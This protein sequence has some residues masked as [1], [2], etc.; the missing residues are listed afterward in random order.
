MTDDRRLRELEEKY[1]GYKVYDNTGDK[2]GKVDDIF[3]DEADREEYIGVKMG[4]FGSRST[5][6]PMELVR[7]NEQERTIEV[8]ESKDHVKDAPTFDDEDE[9]TPEYEDGIRRH[10][11]LESLE[12]SA[13]RG[14]YGRHTEA[15]AG[16]AAE[17]AAEDESGSESRYPA[18]TMSG[19]EDRIRVQESYRNREDMGSESAMSSAG[20]GDATPSGGMRD[21]ETGD[22]SR[23]ED[24]SYREGLREGLLE[25]YREGLREGGSRGEPGGESHG[26]RAGQADAERSGEPTGG[27]GGTQAG[28]QDF[29]QGGSEDRDRGETGSGEETRE[30]SQR[31]SDE[32]TQ[33]EESGPTRVWRRVRRSMGT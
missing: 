10:F 7:V 8:S 22:Q 16:G 33:E 6:I 25:G 4:F 17:S 18:A 20:A 26:E 19:D 21:L 13:E 15:T 3:V 30:T 9:I 24:E 5:L 27:S 32:G 31:S 28:G 1:E 23:M 14:P 11:G 2:V 29:G 12:S